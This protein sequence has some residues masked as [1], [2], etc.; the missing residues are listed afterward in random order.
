MSAHCHEH[1]YDN[2]RPP[3]GAFTRALWV[4]LVVNLAMFFVEIAVGWQSHSVSLLADAIDFGGDAANY[5]V[6]LAVLGLAAPWR[7]RTALWKGWTMIAFGV[8]VA[9]KTMWNVGQG[10]VPEAMSMGVIGALALAANVGVAFLLYVYRNGD[11]NMRS[12]WLCTR[13]DALGNVAVMLAA[14]GVFGTG[15]LWPDV[16]V[17]G[18]MAA[19]AIQSGVQVIRQA[20]S[21]LA[22]FKAKPV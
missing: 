4:A 6:S 12:V 10:A 22:S 3:S 14:V 20:N 5:A 1:N 11:A 7:S 16:L 17:A 13:N 8:V 9:A 2:E 21:E 18:F 15:T 19:L